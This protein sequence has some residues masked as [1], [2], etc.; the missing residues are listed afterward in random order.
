M[1]RKTWAP[2]WNSAVMRW[3]E[4]QMLQNLADECSHHFRQRQVRWSSKS[5][6]LILALAFHRET[7]N[8]R[9]AR[10]QSS[11]M[12]CYA[13]DMIHFA[14]TLLLHQRSLSLRLS[15]NHLWLPDL[16]R[17]FFFLIS[18]LSRSLRCGN[19]LDV[20]CAEAYG[21]ES[22]K[23][24]DSNEMKIQ[25]SFNISS[26]SRASYNRIFILRMVNAKQASVWNIHFKFLRRSLWAKQT[27]AIRFQT[28]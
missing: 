1:R 18:L 19:S 27:S 22:R 14:V 5:Q 9:S 17:S 15:S 2:T 26:H 11:V 16:S 13:T 24:H 28:V 25:F 20:H 23:S 8:H 3:Q 12:N 4:K 6:T 21:G 10:R 7:T